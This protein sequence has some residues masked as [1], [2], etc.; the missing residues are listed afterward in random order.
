MPS[1]SRASRARW[2]PSDESA[3]LADGVARLGVDGC[4]GA[5]R[6]FSFATAWLSARGRGA[7]W[8]DLSDESLGQDGAEWLL[9]F[10]AGKTRLAEIAADDL[11]QALDALIPWY[12]KRRLEDEAPTHFEAP[13][14]NRHA[15]D[16][17]AAGARPCTSACRSCSASSS[18][19]RSPAA[20]CR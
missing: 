10:L 19:P 13:T 4:R 20:G 15:I 5:K 16:Y 8:P 18:I 7:E 17:E 6:R 2:R 3:A 9:P 11:G 1:S 12:L 14:G